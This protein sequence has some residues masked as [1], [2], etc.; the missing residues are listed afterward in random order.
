MDAMGNFSVLSTLKLI[1][2]LFLMYEEAEC[3]ANFKHHLRYF[4]KLHSYQHS[5]RSESQARE[6]HSEP[7]I[8]DYTELQ[9]WR[10]LSKVRLAN[11][12]LALASSW[13]NAPLLL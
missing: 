1:K 8:K 12:Q 5:A 9:G 7:T 4:Q 2:A 6:E 3:H 11:P 10:Q 13:E